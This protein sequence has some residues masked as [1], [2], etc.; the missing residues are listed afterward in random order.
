[1]FKDCNIII[2]DYLGKVKTK[3]KSNILLILKKL[4]SHII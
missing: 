4:P 1:M 2:E 3:F